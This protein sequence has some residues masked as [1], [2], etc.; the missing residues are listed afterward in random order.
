VAVTPGN[1]EFPAG[2]HGYSA[3]E[4]HGQPRGPDR[5]TRQ[6]TTTEENMAQ[7]Q[8]QIGPE[9]ASIVSRLRRAMRRAARAADPDLGLS[10]AQLELLSCITEHP[11]I[12]PSQL[13]RPAQP[14][15]LHHRPSRLAPRLSMIVSRNGRYLSKTAHDHEIRGRRVW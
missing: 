11:G 9:L 3:T 14:D 12:R 13:A 8:E 15:H 10:V 2:N 6:V 4:R 7:E 5:R 1:P